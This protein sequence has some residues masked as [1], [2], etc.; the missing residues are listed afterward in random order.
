VPRGA[1]RLRLTPSPNH[2]D[3]MI[4]TLVRALDQVW[5]RA[6]ARAG[7]VERAL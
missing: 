7:R 4:E 5:N 6:Q 3:D 2:S 1:E